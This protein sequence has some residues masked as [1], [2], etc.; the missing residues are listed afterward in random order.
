MYPFHQTYAPL[1]RPSHKPTILT[2]FLLNLSHLILLLVLHPSYPSP[3]TTSSSSFISPSSSSNLF[4]F[5]LSSFYFSISYL[6]P[7]P[8]LTLL[9]ILFL[10]SL[11]L[12]SSRWRR[13]GEGRDG[14]NGWR[15]WE[16][17]RGSSRVSRKC[18]DDKSRVLQAERKPR[19]PASRSRSPR[20]AGDGSGEM[21]FILCC[22]F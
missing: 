20:A 17:R 21:S 6:S 5:F 16:G 3:F 14:E 10:S 12:P 1:V 15:G 19:P 9:L 7:P 18:N 13:G 8:Y 11:L 2:L 22:M 4:P